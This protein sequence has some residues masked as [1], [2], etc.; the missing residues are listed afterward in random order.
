MHHHGDGHESQSD[1]H[2]HVF[3]FSLKLVGSHRVRPAIVALHMVL[4]SSVFK[5]MGDC[6]HEINIVEVLVVVSL[7]QLLGNVD[8]TVLLIKLL[9]MVLLR[10]MV[11]VMSR[12]ESEMKR[13]V[14]KLF[15][16]VLHMVSVTKSQFI[17]VVS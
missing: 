15:R 8:L 5:N 3:L 12:V 7:I 17:K 4:V 11:V 6:L 2:M 13:V 9:S 1:L 14:S 10:T 16:N